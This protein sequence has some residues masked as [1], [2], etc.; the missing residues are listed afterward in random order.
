MN[1]YFKKLS[2]IFF[3]L[4]ISLNIHAKGDLPEPS[5]KPMHSSLSTMLTNVMPAVVNIRGEGDSKAD[6]PF[7]EHDFQ[8]RGQAPRKPGV[9][10]NGHFVSIGSGVIVDAKMGYIITNAHV[11]Y[12]AD[13]ITIT[14]N[15]GR[16][17]KG[18]L[19]GM[20]VG[21]DIAVLQIKATNLTALTMADSTQLK[22]GDFVAAIGNP[23]NLRQTVTT[24]IISALHRAIHI[25]G[26]EDFIQTDAAINVG[27]SG[28]ALVNNQGQL[29]GLNTAIL[30]PDGGNIGIGFAIPI[31]LAKDVLEQILKYGHI[32]RGVM[33][34]L[35]QDLT[36]D[37]AAS[38]GV[39]N[40]QGALVSQ[41]NPGSPA[42]QANFIVGDIIEAV[43]GKKFT[44]A[45]EIRNSIGLYRPGT[46]LTITI[47]RDGQE[48]T[49]KTT[50][51]DQ[52][53][54]KE[55]TSKLDH[56]ILS[57]VSFE[58][59]NQQTVK[60]GHVTG[61]EIIYVD[62]NSDAWSSDLRPGDV[63]I[64]ANRQVIKNLQDFETILQNN[65]QRL[66]LHVLRQE[67][68]FYMVIP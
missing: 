64:S 39:P 62:P 18:H 61:V 1:H 67:G 32:E 63:I 29:V 53:E 2:I 24:G 16:R 41:V 14:L 54:Y 35:I 65:K 66:L 44:T 12:D 49:L 23:F 9:P 48:K 6:N 25:E 19:V 59:F 60:F 20:D 55:R 47:L 37:L 31:N 17:F 22:I 4:F 34:V 21:F 15:D 30:A 58:N 40:A 3:G 50:I 10:A 28:G 68:A 8:G 42:Q 43:N 11:I 5:N 7:T 36:P 57:G 13:N 52:K 33:G 26:N 56:S 45:S 38:F 46:I 51:I 27:S